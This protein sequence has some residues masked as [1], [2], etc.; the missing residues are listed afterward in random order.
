MIGTLK[1][2][3]LNRDGTQNITVTVQA[4][5]REEF[6]DLYDQEVSVEIKK[7]SKRR[8]LDANAY[9]WVLIDKLAEKMHMKKSEVYRNAIRDIG[10]VS[11]VICVM[12]EAVPSL[13]SGWNAHGTGWQA[14][15]AKSKLPGC[16]NVTLYYG[17]SVYDSRQMAALID[18]LIQDC[19]SCGIST[20]TEQEKEK[21]LGRWTVKQQKKVSV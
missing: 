13:C 3:T 2:L 16:T 7:Y 8:S 5:F 15:T 20:I 10:G 1:D 21:L 12:D 6:D 9:A 17:S 19:E 18:S 11:T 14:E 4:D